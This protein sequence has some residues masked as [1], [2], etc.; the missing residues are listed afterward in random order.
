MKVCIFKGDTGSLETVYSRWKTEANWD[1]YGIDVDV[2]TYRRDLQKLVDNKDAELLVLV[3]GEDV[4]GYIGITTFTS[5]FSNQK[6][7]SEHYWYVLPEHRGIGSIRLLKAAF[8]WAKENGCSHVL[9]NASMLASS[10]HDKVCGI[11]EKMGMKK[12]E[13]QYIMRL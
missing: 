2:E 11:Y 12:F 1:G 4:L 5:P 3:N 9:M 8:I 7:A 10:L 13:T 6:I